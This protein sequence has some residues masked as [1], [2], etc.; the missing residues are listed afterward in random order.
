MYAHPKPQA[1]EQLVIL[2]H[3]KVA[4]S[5]GLLDGSGPLLPSRY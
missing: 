4:P 5:W 3:L 1:V 2:K